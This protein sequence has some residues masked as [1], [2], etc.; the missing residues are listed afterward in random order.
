MSPGLCSRR[1]WAP[2]VFEEVRTRGGFKCTVRVNNREYRT[3]EEYTSPDLAREAAA[4]QAYLICRCFSVND[5]QRQDRDGLV[6]GLPVAI[7]TGRRNGNSQ[8]VHADEASSFASSSES[9]LRAGIAVWPY[10]P[11]KQI[12]LA[13]SESGSDRRSSNG[14]MML[15]R[16]C[17]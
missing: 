3:A 11:N 9:S 12:M 17:I 5:G 10:N 16:S 7:G 1:K 2:P 6:Q 15:D 14:S 8:S 13:E 4:E